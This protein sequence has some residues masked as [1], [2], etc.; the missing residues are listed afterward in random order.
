MIQRFL[1][2]V[3]LLATVGWMAFIMLTASSGDPGVPN[4]GP[5]DPGA[6]AKAVLGHLALF[7]V[8][9][10]LVSHDIHLL[11]VRQRAYL[12]VTAAFLLGLVWGI[13]TEVYQAYVPG[14]ESSLLDMLTN[15]IGAICGGFVVVI[16]NRVIR[17]L[18]LPKL[19][20]GSDN[21]ISMRRGGEV[22]GRAGGQD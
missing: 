21:R 14:R 19:S 4:L 20:A 8:L 10:A 16:L 12:A 13:T 22:R 1:F 18:I 11:P 6:Q 9:G 5:G 7:G 17:F 15:V 2:V 3:S